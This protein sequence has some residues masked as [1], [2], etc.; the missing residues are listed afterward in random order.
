MIVGAALAGALAITDHYFGLARALILFAL[1]WASYAISVRV[2]EP[3]RQAEAV[4]FQ[5]SI[6]PRWSLILRDYE[7][8]ETN[9]EEAL[10]STTRMPWKYNVVE[11]GVRLTFLTPRLVYDHSDHTFST[12]VHLVRWL[13]GKSENELWWS[14]PKVYLFECSEGYEIGLV[15]AASTQQGSK[16]LEEPDGRIKLAVIPHI[17]FVLYLNPNILGNYSARSLKKFERLMH[18]RKES[19]LAHGWE[20]TTG[21]R[22]PGEKSRETFL[23]HKYFSLVHEKV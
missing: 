1:L 17:E 22:I 6:Q 2:F 11:D 21:P 13:R 8:H 15:T 4:P 5:L 18:A 23:E 14:V 12:N 3:R 7:I 10:E 16:S 9:L 19:R 20:D